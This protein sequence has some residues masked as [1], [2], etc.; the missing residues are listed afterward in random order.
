MHDQFVTLLAPVGGVYDIVFLPSDAAVVCQS[1]MLALVRFDMLQWPGDVIYTMD[2]RHTILVESIFG[3]APAARNYGDPIDLHGLQ[4][5][6]CQ[7]AS[8]VGTSTRSR[9]ETSGRCHSLP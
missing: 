4:Q 3:F 8:C 5:S 9:Q 2:V 6:R 7:I 1:L